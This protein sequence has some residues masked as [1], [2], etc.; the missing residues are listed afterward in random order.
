MVSYVKSSDVASFENSE[1][2]E[3]MVGKKIYFIP[4]I[5]L[6]FQEMI[7]R[8]ID[9]KEKSLASRG[10]RIKRNLA[11][12]FVYD[13]MESNSDFDDELWKPTS[14][15]ELKNKSIKFYICC[16]M[17][18]KTFGKVLVFESFIRYGINKFKKYLDFYNISHG[19]FTGEEQELRYKNLENFQDVENNKGN[20]IK[21]FI[22]STAAKEG[23]SFTYIT[24]MFIL[25]SSWNEAS[26][27]QIIGRS[28]RLDSHKGSE[29]E[30]VNIYFLHLK[31]DKIQT[32]DE[33]IFEIMINKFKIFNKMYK[34]YKKSSIEYIN[35]VV[36][37]K[38]LSIK[39]FTSLYDQ[40][41]DEDKKMS[42]RIQ[43]DKDVEVI[44][45]TYDK[46]AKKY[47]IGYKLDNC[48]YDENGFKVGTIAI[49]EYYKILDKKLIVLINMD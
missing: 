22:I 3:R 21:V 11:C 27:S 16:Q 39:E 28:I 12:Q 31:I 30:N 35:E 46:T 10:F 44:F 17:I 1:R 48:V 23:L 41:I 6:K 24:D 34:I 13:G 40:K 45:Y 49:P 2:T 7:Y 15:D 25:T 18:K 5:P 37:S 9:K 36:K 19:T 14:E 29:I 43:I 20:L 33:E 4:V 26:L 32:A 38:E 47:Y 42:D 8:K